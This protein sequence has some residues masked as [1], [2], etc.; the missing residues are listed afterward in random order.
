MC[1][2]FGD[3]VTVFRSPFE[4]LDEARDKNYLLQKIIEVS[5]EWVLWIDGDEALELAGPEQLRAAAD[6]AGDISTY[7]LRIAYLWN[8]PQHVRVDGVWGQ[9]ARLSFFRL[10]GQ[11]AGRLHF[12]AT[13][14]GGNFHCGNVPQGL[15]GGWSHLPVWLQQFGYMTP[16]QRRAKHAWYT[17][18]DPDNPDQ[19]N[20][21]H[22]AEVPG[23]RFA[24][25]PP[26]I[27]PWTE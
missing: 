20:C 8:D 12:P 24:P 27:V 13:G 9:F 18:I 21:R 23:A 3:R 6:G 2:S 19:D 16:E 7:A 17:G 1:E 4:G 14:R 15:V 10:E 25:G 5:P 11:P 26:E 22:L